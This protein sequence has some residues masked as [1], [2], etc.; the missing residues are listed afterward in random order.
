[1][2]IFV[3]LALLS[4]ILSACAKSNSSTQIDSTQL[5]TITSPLP[6]ESILNPEANMPVS[7]VL[8]EQDLYDFELLRFDWTKE[9][10]EELGLEKKV[11]DGA[12]ETTYSNDYISY[13]YLDYW[14]ENAPGIID[15]F[16]ECD[17]PR[18]ISVGD[19]F[20]DVMA[21]FPQDEDWRSNANGVFYGQFDKYKERP[22]GSTGYVSTDDSGDKAI[23]F[24]T[25]KSAWMRMFFQGD[26]VT[27]YTIYLIGS[28]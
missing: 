27:H 16:G 25:D 24:T 28:D 20:D 17:G 19:K 4:M 3:F 5:E 6:M 11:N 13:S 10:M 18:D 21:L 14:E 15:V 2:K 23:T 12:G 22:I 8:T 9:Q 26:E 7:V 1:M